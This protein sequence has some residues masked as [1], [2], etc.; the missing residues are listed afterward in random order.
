MADGVGG[1][2][3]GCYFM[4]WIGGSKVLMMTMHKSR[5]SNLCRTCIVKCFLRYLSFVLMKV[6]VF[7]Q[8]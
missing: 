8:Y 3:F 1:G 4:V 5:S 2:W 6:N 7:E